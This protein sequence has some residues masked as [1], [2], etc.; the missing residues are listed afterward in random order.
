MY[1]EILLDF[2]K[3]DGKETIENIKRI[4]KYPT[5]IKYGSTYGT[6]NPI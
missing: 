3:D 5:N 2:C 1:D 6:L 4:I